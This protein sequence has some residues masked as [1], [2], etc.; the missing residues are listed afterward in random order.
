VPQQQHNMNS[1]NPNVTRRR[2]LKTS[3]LSVGALTI[4]SQGTALA[5]SISIPQTDHTLKRTAPDVTPLKK[6]NEYQGGIVGTV[7]IE[8]PIKNESC[9]GSD[10]VTYQCEIRLSL[11]S[12]PE[13]FLANT[14]VA[15][16]QYFVAWCGLTGSIWSAHLKAPHGFS[17]APIG[18]QQPE[19]TSQTI[20]IS[21]NDFHTGIQTDV[22]ASGQNVV[23]V[24]ARGLLKRVSDG[25]VMEMDWTEWRET[26]WN[27]CGQ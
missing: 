4:L 23:A 21:G 15:N 11:A 16:Q 9:M 19:W 5:E 13:D 22:Q 17:T 1:I 10:R 24:R 20:N 8:S 18:E 3:A 25:H 7:T 12:H 26:V 14:T 2:F 27:H 6:P